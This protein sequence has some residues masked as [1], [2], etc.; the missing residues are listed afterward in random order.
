VK[1]VF[2]RNDVI[3]SLAKVKKIKPECIK[4]IDG[5]G[6]DIAVAEIDIVKKAAKKEKDLTTRKFKVADPEKKIKKGEEPEYIKTAE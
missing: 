4:I 2:T 1:I 6:E 3:D 5:I